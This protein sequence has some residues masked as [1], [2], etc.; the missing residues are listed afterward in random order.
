MKPQRTEAQKMLAKARRTVNEDRLAKML[1][2]A[3]IGFFREYRFH[4]ERK[5]RFDFV[6]VSEGVSTLAVEIEGGIWNQGAHV[7][8]KHFESDCEKY[9]T[10]ALAGWRVLRFSTRMVWDSRTNHSE[11]IDVIKQALR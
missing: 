1:N 10:A 9:N 2:D 11:A 8:G 4:P 3:G 5:W 6:I 7:R